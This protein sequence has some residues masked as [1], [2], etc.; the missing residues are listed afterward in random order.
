MARN[1]CADPIAIERLQL[2]LRVKVAILRSS[3]GGL[4]EIQYDVRPEGVVNFAHDAFVVVR[5]DGSHYELSVDSSG[6]KSPRYDELPAPIG[7]RLVG[8]CSTPPL[9]ASRRCGVLGPRIK[10]RKAEI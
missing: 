8:Q 5:Y 9:R 7:D 2:A 6:E 3:G 1:Y 4:Y 10:H